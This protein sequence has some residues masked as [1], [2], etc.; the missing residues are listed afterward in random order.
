M[1]KEQFEMI[2]NQLAKTN[3]MITKGNLEIDEDIG[4]RTEDL[5]LN[6][7][8]VA[9]ELINCVKEC[10]ALCLKADVPER[11]YANVKFDDEYFGVDTNSCYTTH[12]DFGRTFEY[13]TIATMGSGRWKTSWTPYIDLLS[14]EKFGN[15]DEIKNVTQSKLKNAERLLKNHNVEDIKSEIREQYS[16]YIQETIESRM[17][18]LEQ[19]MSI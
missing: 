19:R 11:H 14:D 18:A 10:D 16:H 13:K 12:D 3:E 9:I 1:N 17:K 8:E 6:F 2:V 4:T 5:K 15:K 7:T